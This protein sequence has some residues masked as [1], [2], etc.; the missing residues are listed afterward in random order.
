MY[1]WHE[2]ILRQFDWRA[3]SSGFYLFLITLFEVSHNRTELLSFFPSSALAA[4][5]RLV[6]I[7]TSPS[8][9]SPVIPQRVKRRAFCFF[10]MRLEEHVSFYAEGIQG[11][12]LQ[13]NC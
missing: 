1:G 10:T 2:I 6:H 13:C 4:S 5:I 7:R 8:F 9:P 11:E 3:G 12:E